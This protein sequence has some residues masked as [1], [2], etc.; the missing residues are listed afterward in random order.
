VR[1][2]R[3]AETAHQRGVRR[4]EEDQRRIQSFHPPQLP[5]GSRELGDEVLLA[6]V[7][8]DGDA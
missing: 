1:P 3:L 7:D 8:D 5:V 4:F 2:A 6:D